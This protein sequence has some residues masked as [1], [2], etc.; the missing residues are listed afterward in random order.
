MIVD[1]AA[2]ETGLAVSY[3]RLFRYHTAA[4][5]LRPGTSC[6]ELIAGGGQAAAEGPRG[7]KERT[8]NGE[9]KMKRGCDRVEEM[10]SDRGDRGLDYPENLDRGVEGGTDH[11]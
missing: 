5:Q 1:L 10:I 9:W 3:I 6:P 7:E 8:G 2:K 4:P 11:G